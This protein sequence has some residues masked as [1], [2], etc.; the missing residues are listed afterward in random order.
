MMEADYRDCANRFYEPT[1]ADSEFAIGKMLNANVKVES[2]QVAP[3]FLR[4]YE[5]VVKTPKAK[6]TMV[7]DEK[8][9]NCYEIK[10]LYSRK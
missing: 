8:V 9:I 3:N 6:L 7:C 5:I 1:V 10:K 4:A 2:I